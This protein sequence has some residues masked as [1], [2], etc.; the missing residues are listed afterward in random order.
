MKV[1]E[2]ENNE[3]L[4]K[5]YAHSGDEAKNYIFQQILTFPE[6]K[7]IYK[8]WTMQE[9]SDFIKN[10]EKIYDENRHLRMQI[11]DLKKKLK[12]IEKILEF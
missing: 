11:H 6:N 1:F 7:I 10:S 3:N 5:I 2:L 4:A 8:G 9:F 12:Q